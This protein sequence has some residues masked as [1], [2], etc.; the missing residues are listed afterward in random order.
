MS[1]RNNKQKVVL[2]TGCT[3]GGI[4]AC[5]AIEFAQNG[6]I[7]YATARRLEAMS[8]LKALGI[9]TSILDVTQVETMK[10]AVN[11][12]VD[13]EGRVDILVNNAGMTRPAPMIDQDLDIARGVYETNL[14]GPLTL[15]QMVAPHMM[16]R[17][18]GTIVNVA[19]IAAVCPLPWSG[20]Y[21]SVKAALR[22]TSD[23]LRLELL[24]F[25]VNVVSVF[26]GAIQSNIS[27]NSAQEFTWKEGSMY[28]PFKSRVEERIHISQQ[29]GCTPT[30]DFA[31]QVVRDILKPTPPHDIYGGTYSTLFGF[32]HLCRPGSRQAGLESMPV[33]S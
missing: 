17:R 24:S 25:N 26:P 2:I 3:E 29:P 9:H 10:T 16:K 31:R 30:V 27:A 15:I 8:G 1:V 20:I 18:S 22:A 23:V 14:W 11:T 33:N 32:F 13:A 7:V 21:A 6:C 5:L 28:E 12:I 19:S 4:G